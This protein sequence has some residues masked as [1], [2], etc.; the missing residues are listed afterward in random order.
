MYESYFGL[1]AR[2]FD[3]TP[4]PAYLVPLEQHREAVS[5]LEYALGA[6]RGLVVLTGEAGTGKTTVLRAAL[7]RTAAEQH[8]VL[9]QN[10]SLTRAEFLEFLA[11]SFGLTTRAA[12][13]KAH[14]L[15]ELADRLTMFR[16]HGRRCALV[17]DE[18]QSL[19]T[20]LLEEVRLL[21]NFETDTE[22]LL[23]IALIGQPELRDRLNRPEL[24]QLKQRVALRCELRPL[25]FTDTCAYIA[26]RVHTA[27]SDRNLF[28]RE[29]LRLIHQRSS[30]IARSVNVI[31]DNALIAAL[32]AGAPIAGEAH[33]REV[34]QDLD[35]GGSV[36]PVADPRPEATGAPENAAAEEQKT[37]PPTVTPPSPVEPR[38]AA[39][40]PAANPGRDRALFTMFAPR[41]RLWLFR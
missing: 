10:P 9:L 41:R 40:G 17:V 11:L 3:L 23:P 4:N 18:A 19:G 25:T 29:A 39:A 28:T 8:V 2:P 21:G 14:L 33:V 36:A 22:K 24:R 16:A 15:R 34:C 31:C 27:G 20:E 6:G 26:A 13:S 7:A 12:A 32:A 1:K 37:P 30:G 5:M 38:T 35:F